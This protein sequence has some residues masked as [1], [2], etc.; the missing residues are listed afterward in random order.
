MRV[1]VADDDAFARRVIKGT[2]QDAGMIVVAEAADGREAVELGL[3]Y[4]PDVIVMDVVMPGLD[5]ILAT[6]KILQGNPGQLVVVLTS[7]GEEDFGLLALRAGA[8]GFLSKD[9]DLK[10]LPRALA[11]VL[12]G[13]GAVSRTMTLRLIEHYRDR[14]EGSAGL[15]P[16]R[17]P[18]T[19][20]E[21]E[22][23]D[24]LKPDRTTAQVAD[25][26]VLSHET[27]RSHL[28]NIMRKLD[29]HSRADAV[30]AVEQLR[31]TAPGA[32]C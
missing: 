19:A 7:A 3:H 22:V 28:K 4:R 1:I 18:L 5:G 2:L 12:D 29:V 21:W 10:A 17:G 25:K 32:P 14:P 9:M 27:V 6:R 16:I 13:E 30:A 31:A 15:R 23:I 11:A 26:L 20:R 24:L 8:V